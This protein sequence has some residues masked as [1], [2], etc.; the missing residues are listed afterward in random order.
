M[1]RRPE[2]RYYRGNKDHKG[3]RYA[4]IQWSLALVAVR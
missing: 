4:T 1:Y 2:G 3:S